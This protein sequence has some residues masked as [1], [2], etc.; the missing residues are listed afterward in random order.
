MFVNFN[1]F[2]KSIKTD[3]LEIL[4]QL[5]GTRSNMGM[6][7][8][9]HIDEITREM[10][11]K[12]GN[13][14]IERLRIIEKSEEFEYYNFFYSGN[15]IF[16]DDGKLTYTIRLKKYTI[17]ISNQNQFREVNGIE[18]FI[19]L[20]VFNSYKDV[21]QLDNSLNM[22]DAKLLVYIKNGIYQGCVW[23]MENEFFIGFY[24][25]RSS[26]S[27]YLNKRK[28]VAQQI[29]NHIKSIAN[30]RTI[31]VPWP[32]KSMKSLLFRNNFIEHNEHSDTPERI[33]L[34]PYA[35]TSNYFTLDIT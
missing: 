1:D 20:E 2:E 28:G 26:L 13:L 5:V 29:I 11:N 7:T 21:F 27:N 25:I 6:G 3:E 18:V 24:G 30:G 23:V 16:N 10:Y 9:Y 33:F 14:L 35:D 19:A 34:R 17:N 31:I 15:L 32:L 4:S 22:T 8:I 12:Y